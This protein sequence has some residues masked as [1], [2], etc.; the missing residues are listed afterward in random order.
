[1]KTANTDEEIKKILLRTLPEDLYELSNKLRDEDEE[2]EKFWVTQVY[3]KEYTKENIK[4]LHSE[5]RFALETVEEVRIKDFGNFSTMNRYLDE[6]DKFIFEHN[7]KILES[8][9][10]KI[11]EYF[12]QQGIETTLPQK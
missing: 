3:K 6:Q 9:K 11:I 5:I 7:M 1:L 8:K 10:N 4:F 2:I 12:L